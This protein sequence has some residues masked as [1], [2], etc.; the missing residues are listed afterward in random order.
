MGHDQLISDGEILNVLKDIYI[1]ALKRPVD[2][3]L[4]GDNLAVYRSFLFFMAQTKL[5]PPQSLSMFGKVRN[6]KRPMNSDI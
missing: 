6:I 5:L 4:D 3:P 2:N 1:T